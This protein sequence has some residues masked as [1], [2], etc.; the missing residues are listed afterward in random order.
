[1][2]Q[3]T[4]RE[5]EGKACDA[6]LR[7]LEAR[8]EGSRRDLKL[9]DNDPDPNARVELTCRI[10]G[11]LFA[12]EHSFVEPF[13]GHTAL[14]FAF[15]SLQRSIRDEISGKIPSTENFQL[16]IPVKALLGLRNREIP[17][18]KDA[19]VKWILEVAELLPIAPFGEHIRGVAPVS[20]PGVPFNVTLH[21]RASGAF[22]SPFCI[23]VFVDTTMESDRRDRI[24]RTY[25][26]KCPKLKA[27]KDRS[28]ARTVL[29][30][31]EH[32]IS[33][34]NYSLITDAVCDIEKT[35][36]YRPDEIYLVETSI[37]PWFLHR[38]RVDDQ[39]FRGTEILGDRLREIDPLNLLPLT[40]PG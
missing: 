15:Q 23:A 32:D 2:A 25:E 19:L 4:R 16:F 14:E 28:N 39:Y 27:H 29:I 26:D 35:Y 33:L 3:E 6:I 18:I 9:H 10:G 22:P 38:I 12:L 21:R 20:V 8:E 31:E 36:L 1:M 34:T 17:A 5:S 30:L 11:T 13:E 7:W 37:D 24:L 40:S